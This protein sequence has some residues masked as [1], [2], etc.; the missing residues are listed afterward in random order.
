MILKKIFSMKKLLT[1][2]L[3]VPILSL[4]AQVDSD[5]AAKSTE[6]DKLADTIIQLLKDDNRILQLQQNSADYFDQ[7]AA[8][9]KVGEYILSCL[10]NE[11]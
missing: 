10:A 4:S 11:R 6:Y 7:H 5:S 1:I 8:P 2:S 9:L 3:L